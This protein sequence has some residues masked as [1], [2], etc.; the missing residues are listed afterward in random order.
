MGLLDELHE[1]GTPQISIKV[2]AGAKRRKQPLFVEIT[3][4]GFDRTSICWQHHEHSRKIVEGI[5]DDQQWF[6]Y[7]CGLDEA[8]DPLA[9]ESCWIKANPNLGTSIGYEYL[10]RQVKNAINI[11]GETNTVLRLNFCVWTQAD[12]RAI[13]MDQWRGCQAMPSEAEL[14]KAPCFGCLDLGETDDFTAWGCLWLLDD[15]RVAVKMRYWVPQIAMERYPNR[16]YAEWQRAGLLEV[17]GEEVTDYASVRERISDDHAKLGMK[18]IFYDTKTARETAQILMAQGM[19]LVPMTQG[20]ALNEAIKRLLGL[21]ASSDLCHG[22]DPI[23]SWM[24]SNTVVLMGIKGGRRLA[25]ERSQ[26]KID[27]IAALVMGIEG[28]IVRRERVIEAPPQ[29]FFVGTKR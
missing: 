25:K 27:G 16:P 29:L 13:D 23:L 2:R 20:F 9:D 17:K 24:A 1:H 14:I 28:A 15:G 22:D 12:N 4:S 3:N 26:E 21:V 18:S 5:V 8:D 19:D 11:P 10:R 6:A 7:V